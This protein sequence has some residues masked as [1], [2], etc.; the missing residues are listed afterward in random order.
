MDRGPQ[1]RSLYN[2]ATL[3]RAGQVVARKP[4]QAAPQPDVHRRR[5]LRLQATHL[6]EH[7]GEWQR[8]ALEEQLAGEH[9]PVAGD[10]RGQAASPTVVGEMPRAAA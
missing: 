8:G 7:A 1:Q 5:V 4:G 6:F 2:L 10:R 3:Q 9:R